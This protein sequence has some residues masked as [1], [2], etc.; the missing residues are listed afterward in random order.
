MS[1]KFYPSFEL[2]E[3]DSAYSLWDALSP[4]KSIDPEGIDTFIFRGQADA[5]WG[6]LPSALRE[7]SFYLS[8]AGTNFSEDVVWNEIEIINSFVTYCDRIGIKIPGDSQAFRQQHLNMLHQ[9]KWVDKPS[10]WPN[11]EI[12]DLLAMAQHHGVPTRLLDW[13]SQPYVALFFAISQSLSRTDDWTKETKLALWALNTSRICRHPE[14]RIYRAAGAISPHLAAQHGLFTIHQHRGG[15]GRTI[16]VEGLEELTDDLPDPVFY[17]YTLP[18]NEVIKLYKL[19]EKAGYNAA[20]IYPSA[21]GVGK[22]VI[23]KINFYKAEDTLKA[24]YGL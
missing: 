21:D 20:S 17:K 8:R 1:N 15:Y 13:T 9:G 16:T 23:D 4:T 6:L 24:L 14:I 22:A 11:P 7:N 2:K 19:L 12:L 5:T 10:L 3:F 18:I